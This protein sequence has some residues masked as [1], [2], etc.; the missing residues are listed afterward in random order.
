MIFLPKTKKNLLRRKKIILWSVLALLFFFFSLSPLLAACRSS[1]NTNIDININIDS[2]TNLDPNTNMNILD[3]GNYYQG[4]YGFLDG[5]KNENPIESLDKMA[6][7]NINLVILYGT[8]YDVKTT[9]KSK[10][11][12]VLERQFKKIDRYLARA[13]TL[14]IQV[15]MPVWRM[16][17]NLNQVPYMDAGKLDTAE[18]YI[19][20]YRDNPTVIGWY[21]LD[22]PIMRLERVKEKAPEYLHKYVIPALD[23]LTKAL[24]EYDTSNKI[25]FGVIE[26]HDRGEYG[27]EKAGVM[28]INR[29][30]TVWGNDRYPFMKRAPREFQNIYYVIKGFHPLDDF[31]RKIKKP[32]LFIGQAQSSDANPTWQ[33]R[34]PTEREFLVQQVYPMLVMSDEEPRYHLGNASWAF[35]V[36][37][38]SEAGREFLQNVYSKGKKTIDLIS[39]GIF[40]GRIKNISTNVVIPRYIGQ[41]AIK[42]GLYDIPQD[43]LMFDARAWHPHPY[44]GKKMAVALATRNG[45]KERF[46]F[47]YPG[48]VTSVQM[49]LSEQDSICKI[50]NFQQQYD[51]DKQE[52]LFQ[53]QIMPLCPTVLFFDTEK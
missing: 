1:F 19:K 41:K 36:M 10:K 20:R 40:N 50:E 15:I 52:T 4:V 5:F 24:D 27:L 7:N 33:Q 49:P 37:R 14:G 45:R 44:R 46:S 9:V 13:A 18:R 30:L 2:N 35:G 53:M 42:A 39:A 51:R 26:R 23:T 16:P 38:S 29:Y 22:E 28:L 48:K 34:M 43:S 32:F 21:I 11:D 25:R 31:V 8:N 6:K 3:R 17:K 12:A 47:T